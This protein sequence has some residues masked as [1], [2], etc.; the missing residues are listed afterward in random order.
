MTIPMCSSPPTLLAVAYFTRS[1]VGG[2]IPQVFGQLRLILHLI[3][4]RNAD[5]SLKLVNSWKFPRPTRN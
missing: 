5:Y 3:C 2:E 4:I 1:V